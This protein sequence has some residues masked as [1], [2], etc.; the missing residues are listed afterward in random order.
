MIKRVIIAL[1]ILFI[2]GIG[3]IGI[4]INF[5]NSW[6]SIEFEDKNLESIIRDHVNNPQGALLKKQLE[7]ISTLNLYEKEITSLNG[8]ENLS[9]L[10]SLNLENNFI[11]DVSPLTKLEKLETLNLKNNEILCLESINFREL[12]NLS[13]LKHLNLSHNVVRERIEGLTNQKRLSDI[14]ILSEFI[15]L[16]ELDLSDNFI[17]DF[18]PLYALTNL[19]KL[20]ISE[21]DIQIGN[22][23]ALANLNKIEHL[24][25]REC[26]LNDISDI[27]DLVNI[28]YLNLHSNNK[29]ETI[30]PIQN[31]FNLETLILR[32]VYVGE[33]INFLSNLTNLSRVNLRNSCISDLS[34]LANLMSVGA[35]QDNISAGI[36]A[37]IDIRDNPIATVYKEGIDGYEPLRKYWENVNSRNPHNLP[38]LPSYVVYINEFMSSNGDG[39]RDIDGDFSDWIELY[40]PNNYDL[41]I[42]NFYLSDND[43]NITKWRFPE[44]TI[45]SADDFLIVW[46]SGKN[47]VVDG[48]LHTNFSLARMGEPIIITHDCG[49]IIA[50][51]VIPTF[52][53]RG[54][55]YG[56]KPDG[57]KNWHYFHMEHITPASSNNDSIAHVLPQSIAPD[58]SHTGGFYTEEFYL[59]LSAPVGHTVYYTLDGSTPTLNSSIYSEPILIKKETINPNDYEPLFIHNSENP[60]TEIPKGFPIS[61]I[62]TTPYYLNYPNE[63]IFKGVVVR[64]IVVNPYGQKSII[65]TQSFFVDDNIMNR[66]DF[67]VM[68]ITTDVDNLF[69]YH[70]G[71]MVPG[72][73]F[74]YQHSGN[75]LQ[76]QSGNWFMRGEEW[77]RPVFIEFFD[78][79][80]DL[81]FS[82]N[83]GIRIDGSSSRRFPVRSFRLYARASYDEQDYFNYQFFEDK[84]IFMFKRLVLRA[85]GSATL[86]SFIGD[87]IAQHLLKPLDLDIQYSTP[88]IIFINGEY[89]GLRTI[90]DRYDV[91]YLETHYDIDKENATILDMNGRHKDGNLDGVQHYMKMR[92]FILNNDMNCSDNYN[93][94]NTLMDINNFLDYFAVQLYYANVDWPQNNIAYWRL[95]VNYD[96][97]APYGHDGRWRWMVF[98]LDAGFGIAWGGLDP[99]YNSFERITGKDWQS[100]DIFTALL[101]ND[102]F[103]I[104]FIN[105]FADLLNSI[106]EENYVLSIINDFA[107][108]YA[109]EMQEH[110]NRYA[111][112]AT[113][114]NW[115]N[116]M[117]RMRWFG[118]GRP[119]HA[120]VQ[121]IEYFNISDNLS[122][123]TINLDPTMGTVNINSLIINNTFKNTSNLNKWS[124]IYFNEIPIT[125]EAIAND[126]YLFIGWQI[127]EEIITE[128]K[129][130]LSLS[131]DIVITPLFLA[132]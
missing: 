73:N 123:I 104:N 121:L 37:D 6:K 89:F 20:D 97:D 126:G 107:N 68:S 120:R 13:L 75:D 71:I 22:I 31:L 93:Y 32:N 132:L 52:I 39:I 96:P 63:S 115:S 82:Q 94:V 14:S 88:V 3:F 58:F 7:S 28:K 23:A 103:R 106:F 65:K 48:E 8:I 17:T 78:K 98:D 114:E 40:N 77:E 27:K 43:D 25:L 41:D 44:N 70:D 19:R 1:L 91:Y 92:E 29:I 67:P 128:R 50:D 84:E 5:Q 124:G 99:F 108:M 101:L 4:Y 66:Y 119:Y 38:T 11:K 12:K 69:G 55:S 129:L 79:N 26:N 127:N 118:N 42:S 100:G 90:R 2:L 61:L 34:I 95:N 35:L 86:G 116:W 15:K 49:R 122:E 131:N 60:T 74:N 125:L 102:S 24:N 54:F 10:R 113:F 109:L 16:E 130:N 21:N 83:A 59:S 36:Y 46:A 9:N 112:P 47:K 76:N 18:T 110:I 87:D 80:G 57:G 53:P 51:Y 105:R 45:I 30:E 85:G 111:Y 62:N 56:R 81:C 72:A 64:A 117:N 33:E